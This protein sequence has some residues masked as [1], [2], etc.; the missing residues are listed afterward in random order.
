MSGIFDT[1]QQKRPRDYE[2]AEYGYKRE[3][4]DEGEGVSG[5]ELRMMPHHVSSYRGS[6][7]A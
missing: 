5:C 3:D 4:A 1:A 6:T 7:T 2:T